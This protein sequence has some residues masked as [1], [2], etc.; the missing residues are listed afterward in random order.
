MKNIFTARFDLAGSEICRITRTL[1]LNRII[2]VGNLAGGGGIRCL[3]VL[4]ILHTFGRPVFELLMRQEQRAHALH[5][6][7]N[8]L[9]K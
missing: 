3:L 4:V 1:A 6:L 7:I 9:K 5:M 8:R 2:P